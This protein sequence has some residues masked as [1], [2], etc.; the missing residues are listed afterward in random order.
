MVSGDAAGVSRSHEL[1][2]SVDSQFQ[3]LFEAA[4]DG[5]LIVDDSG[6]IALVN[7]QA[8][9]IF[10]YARLELHGQLIELL[11]PERFHTDHVGYRNNYIEHPR[12]RPM[13]CICSIC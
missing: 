1:S 5:I 11:V 13:G 3:A 12:T 4:P 10:G 9:Q 8:E 6:R 2:T 7:E